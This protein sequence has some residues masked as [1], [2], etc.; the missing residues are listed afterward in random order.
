MELRA[1]GA[2]LDGHLHRRCAC[3][4]QTAAHRF[5]SSVETKSPPRRGA[6]NRRHL[7][8]T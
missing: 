8:D 1:C 2:L 4:G 7:W 6:Q 5:E 3:I